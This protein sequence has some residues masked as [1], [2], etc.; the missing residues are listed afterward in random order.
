MEVSACGSNRT[1][2]WAASRSRSNRAA[3]RNW[4]S[5]YSG[6]GT[7][8]SQTHDVPLCGSGQLPSVILIADQPRKNSRGLHFLSPDLVPSHEDVPLPSNNNSVVG[9]ISIA[10][11]ENY[12]VEKTAT[13][14]GD[15]FMAVT[16]VHD[17]EPMWS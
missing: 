16:Y 9:A 1:L 13:D 4:R 8:A 12:L 15:E 2:P 3:G 11:S 10:I 17:E 5:V 6:Q 7:V 14:A